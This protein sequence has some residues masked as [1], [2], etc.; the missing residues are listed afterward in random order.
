MR[1]RTLVRRLVRG[2]DEDPRWA[3]P[4][5]LALLAVT[6]GSLPVGPG[7]VRLG[8]RVLLRGRA[9]HDEELEGLL[10][11][12]VRQR[13][14]H[15]RGQDA[16][17]AVGHGGLGAALRRERLEHPR[18]AGAG[19]RGLGRPAVR[20]RAAVGRPLGPPWA[21]RPGSSPGRPWR[22]RPSPP[23]CSASTTPTRCWCCSWSARPTR[24]SAPWTAA[25]PGGWSAAGALV[26][27]GFMTKM[28]QAFLVVPALVLVYLVAGKPAAVEA[29]VAGRPG[30]RGRGRLGRLVGRR[31]QLWPAASR[32][33][34]GGSQTNSI[35]ELTFGYNGLGRLTGDETGSVGGGA[36]G[37]AGRWGVDRHHAAVP[38]R[39][40]RPDRVAHPGRPGARR[41]R[42]RDRLAR[43][44]YRQAARLRAPVGRL[45]RG[46]GG[47]VQLR[48]R[49]HPPVLRR[50]AGAGHR[51]PRRHRR[52]GALGCA[53]TSSGAGCCWPSRWPARASGP[54]SCSTAA[55]TGCRPCAT[56][57]SA[58]RGGGGAADRRRAA[59]P[60]AAAHRRGGGRP[61]RDAGRPGGL[62]RR[63]R[64]HAAHRLD[65]AGRADRGRLDVRH[66]RRPAAARAACPAAGRPTFAT[67]QDGQDGRPAGRAGRASK[68]RPAAPPPRPA[69]RDDGSDER[70][71]G[72]R[73]RRP[74]RPAR[75]EHA[76][77][78][79]GHAA[80]DGRGPVHL[81]R[82]GRGRQLGRRRAARQPTSPSWP[83]AASTAATPGRR[84]RSSR[85]SWRPARSTTTSPA[86]AAWAADRAAVAG[87][88]S[89]ITSWVTSTF[90]SST[91]G[92][93]TVYDLT[94]AK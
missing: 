58:R 78:G 69:A 73:R 52:G 71:G 80:P 62:R 15:H 6:A 85:R 7:R 68:A 74:R 30:R 94:S 4:L 45:V 24:R 53:A 13:Q 8:Q 67:Q 81:G 25:A 83:S 87:T 43:A 70:P 19:G 63:H 5:L 27:A 77:R 66:G 51:R 90:S 50:R 75:R 39:L 23:S 17:V 57:C 16:G 18:A 12:L 84:S 11:R 46:D 40:G 9:G 37:Q 61:G 44:A 76:E 72:R 55:R 20:G 56:R 49:H 10:L 33:Y 41:G 31:G 3:R 22:S 34:I 38:G 47:G 91:V 36:A 59:R 65:P 54:S 42:P 32:P 26:G 93:V 89:E 14:L 92:G 2:P 48:R 88:S 21:G 35:L 29:P 86:E 64:G 79:A 1:L 60:P 28:L 82:G